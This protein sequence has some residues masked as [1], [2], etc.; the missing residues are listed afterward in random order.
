MSRQ[1]IFK[2]TSANDGTGDTL[3]QAADKINQTFVELYTKFGGDS[4]I[5]MSGVSF[6]SDNI[7]FEGSSV[8]SFSTKLGVVNP[9]ANRTIVLPDASGTLITS[10]SPS[11]TSPTLTTPRINDTSSDHTYIIGVSEL[12]AN[13]TITLPVLNTNDTFVFA[14]A[15]QTLT[16]KTLTTPTLVEPII[17]RSIDDSAGAAILSF[18]SSA[19]AVNNVRLRNAASGSGPTVG[20]VGNDTN[21]NLNL[22]SK[23][24]GAVRHTTKVAYSAETLTSSGAVSLLVPLTIFNSSGSLSMTLANG[25]IVGESKKFVNINSGIATVTPTS[26]GQGTSF[27]LSQNGATEAIWTGAN[28][29]LF[30]DSDNFL[31]IT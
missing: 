18:T 21:I 13:R 20:A 5:L 3:R 12:S 8:D 26:F 30:G 7:I 4:N 15:S 27:S 31:T 29:Y 23:G 24:T 17:Q 25:A 11:I 2:G 19:S 14:A 9:T 10:A 22:A 6:D 16:N 1:N 28:W